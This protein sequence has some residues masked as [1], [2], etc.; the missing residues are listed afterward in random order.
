MGV[1]GQP[2]NKIGE[3]GGIGF[4]DIQVEMVVV[5]VVGGVVGVALEQ[6]NLVV[7]RLDG[8]HRPHHIADVGCAG[9]NQDRFAQFCHA[10]QRIRPR[11]EARTGFVGRNVGIEHINGFVVVGRGEVMN[12]NFV[13]LCFEDGRPLKGHGGIGINFEDA[14]L[15]G[16][17]MG[18]LPAQ[19]FEAI[20]RDDLGGTEVLEFGRVGSGFFRQ[21]NQLFGALQVAVVIGGNIGNE[22]GRVVEAYFLVCDGNFRGRNQHRELLYSKAHQINNNQRGTEVNWTNGIFIHDASSIILFNICG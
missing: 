13:A 10:N 1:I 22:V 3:H 8:T 6:D 14:L 18:E 11:H 7:M 19:R 2:Q 5:R 20:V 15:P 17:L 12:A 9:S 16:S 21:P 4:E